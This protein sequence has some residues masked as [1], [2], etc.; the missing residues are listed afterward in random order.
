MYIL[1]QFTPQIAYQLS[2]LYFMYHLV[3]L[4]LLFQDDCK[5]AVSH[6]EVEPCIIAL[7]S[8]PASLKK[9][10]KKKNNYKN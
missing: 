6:L 1:F 10:C 9:K 3:Q 4:L 8:T 7:E 5:I 2:H